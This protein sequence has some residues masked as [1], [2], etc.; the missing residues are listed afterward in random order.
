VANIINKFQQIPRMSLVQVDMV[1]A[2]ARHI[3]YDTLIS[4]PLAP[5]RFWRSQRHHSL[6][7]AR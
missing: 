1:N 6:S 5:V 4:P 7:E 2:Q 3:E